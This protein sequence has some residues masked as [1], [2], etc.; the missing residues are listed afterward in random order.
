MLSGT[1]GTCIAELAQRDWPD[2]AGDLAAKLAEGTRLLE[3]AV[4][5]IKQQPT[6]YLDL[7]SR[8]LVDM[9]IDVMVGYWFLLQGRDNEAKR[10]VARRWIN[11]RMADVA[12]L[13]GLILSQDRSPI[14]DF[15]V[16]AAPVPAA[17]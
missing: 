14:N 9:A 1:A 6:D 10:T 7:Y 11:T 12:K 8:K 17:D 15:A 5:F 3:A 2:W 16:L 13:H 4:A